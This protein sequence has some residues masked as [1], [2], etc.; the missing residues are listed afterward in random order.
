MIRTPDSTNLVPITYSEAMVLYSDNGRRAFSFVAAP[1][2]VLKTITVDRRTGN[3]MASPPS[4]AWPST[5]RG[6]K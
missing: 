6:G 2:L 1:Y 3:V 4:A 5:S